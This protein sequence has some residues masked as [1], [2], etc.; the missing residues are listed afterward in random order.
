MTRRRER[1]KVEDSATPQKL[2]L[3]K[4][5]APVKFAIRNGM[6]SVDS[7]AVVAAALLS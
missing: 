7:R 2:Q 1:P 5:V 3:E 4:L 6:N